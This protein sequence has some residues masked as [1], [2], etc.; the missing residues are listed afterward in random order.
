MASVPFPRGTESVLVSIASDPREEW[1]YARALAKLMDHVGPCP[2]CA[3]RVRAGTCTGCGV[4]GRVEM[5]CGGAGCGPEQRLCSGCADAHLKGVMTMRMPGDPAPP[6]PAAP[7]PAPSAVFDL[8]DPATPLCEKGVG[9]RAAAAEARAATPA[10]RLIAFY[11][12]ELPDVPAPDAH[13]CARGA[14][15]LRGDPGEARVIMERV[16][17]KAGPLEEREEPTPELRA[18]FLAGFRQRFP[19]RGPAP[20]EEQRA[21]RSRAADRICAVVLDRYERRHGKPPPPEVAQAFRR[22]HDLW[23]MTDDPNTDLERM[24]DDAEAFRARHAGV[25]VKRSILPPKSPA[26]ELK[27]IARWVAEGCIRDEAEKG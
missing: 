15:W 7:L 27:K 11:G 13:D 17:E 21:R 2:D 8:S 24:A 18:A 5:A 23:V 22:S 20:T 1:A 25:W 3:E 19:S 6:A 12:L 10:E 26:E 14:A 4:V 9:L 16:V